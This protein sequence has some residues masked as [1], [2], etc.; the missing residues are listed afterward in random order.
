MTRTNL[1]T[2]LQSFN[3]WLWNVYGDLRGQDMIEYALMAALV[4]LASV[5]ASPQLTGSFS[6]IFSKINSTVLAHG[7][8]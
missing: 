3:A 8:N 4:A 5:A 1:R 6:T 2:H 7:G